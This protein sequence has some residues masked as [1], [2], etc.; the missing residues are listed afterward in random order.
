MQLEI[1]GIGQQ[2]ATLSDW[3]KEN[4]IYTYESNGI[5]KPWSAWGEVEAPWDFGHEYGFDK[6]GLGNTEKEAIWSFCDK[7]GIQPPFWWKT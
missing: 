4:K 1:E 2:K 6:M 5:E 3:K 7:W